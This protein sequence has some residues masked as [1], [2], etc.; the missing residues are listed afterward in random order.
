[1]K[2]YLYK[3]LIIFP[4]LI[5]FTFFI[6]CKNN[7][8]EYLANEK[9]I[10]INNAAL[11]V[12]N[13]DKAPYCKAVLTISS[14]NT[15]SYSESRCLSRTSSKGKWIIKGDTLIIN[16]IIPS[17]C[18]SFEPF[19]LH[20]KNKKYEDC[21]DAEL[22]DIITIFENERFLI[23]KDTLDYLDLK[24]IYKKQYGNY[25]IFK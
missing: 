22:E 16:T 4:L 23:K 8:K 20:T 21:P 19:S 3:I 6:K 9:K 11:G 1:M 17:G 7:E 25:K 13:I 5:I 15:F 10:A 18:Y 12:W 14:N 2:N 24:K